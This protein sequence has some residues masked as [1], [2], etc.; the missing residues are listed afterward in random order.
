MKHRLAIV[1]MA[2]VA[3][4]GSVE[5]R[6]R[7]VKLKVGPFNIEAKRDREV[8]QV[9]RIPNVPAG[10]ELVRWEARSRLRRKGLVRYGMNL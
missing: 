4:V 7:V 10:T 9:L 8:C 2:I 5:A 1:G 6:E 3:V